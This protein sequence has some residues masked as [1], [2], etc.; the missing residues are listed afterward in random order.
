MKVTKKNLNLKTL[1]YRLVKWVLFIP[2]LVGL[3]VYI[4]GLS[5]ELFTIKAT[6]GEHTKQD[7]KNARLW[8]VYLALPFFGPNY[9]EGFVHGM[10]GEE[11]RRMH[12][13]YGKKNFSSKL[14]MY[15]PFVGKK[16]NAFDAVNAKNGLSLEL[17]G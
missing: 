15:V 9:F 12:E 16:L 10:T 3:L 14:K 7:I 6:K 8:F 4:L 2:S 1:C 5:I 13:V 11:L 17:V